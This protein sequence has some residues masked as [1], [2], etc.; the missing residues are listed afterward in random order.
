MVVVHSSHLVRANEI[1]T[2]LRGLAA[3]LDIERER[4]YNAVQSIDRVTGAVW[5]RLD[6][7]EDIVAPLEGVQQAPPRP[8]L[9]N[10]FW[11]CLRLPEWE[12]TGRL[13]ILKASRDEAAQFYGRDWEVH[14]SGWEVHGFSTFEG[15]FRFWRSSGHTERPPYHDRTPYRP[16]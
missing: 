9:Q 12:G 7:L 1:L 13:G 15:A 4:L 2:E 5:E 14:E 8:R 16:G 11:V 10:H 6:A 3:E